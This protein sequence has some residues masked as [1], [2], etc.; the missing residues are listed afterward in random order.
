MIKLDF[1]KEEPLLYC[2]CGG[3]IFD[4]VLGDNVEYCICD[5]CSSVFDYKEIEDALRKINSFKKN[6]ESRR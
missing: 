4:F 6:L 3:E 5:K 1:N 2:E